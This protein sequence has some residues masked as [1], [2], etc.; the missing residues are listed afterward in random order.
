MCTDIRPGST[1][2]PAEFSLLLPNGGTIRHILLG[3]PADI[4]QTRHLLH[5][6]RY[7]EISQWSPSSSSWTGK[8]SSPPIR[9]NR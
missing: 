1:P 8:S 4:H 7:A 5:N 6:L 9:A 3:T 2:L